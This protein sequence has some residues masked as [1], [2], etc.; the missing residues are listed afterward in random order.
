MCANGHAG[1]PGIHPDAWI[2]ADN[3]MKAPASRTF[4]FL[5]SISS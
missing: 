4:I 5:G 3:A 2:A 1:D